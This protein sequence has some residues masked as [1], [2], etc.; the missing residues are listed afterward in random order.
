[1]TIGEFFGTLQ[2]SITAEWRKHLQTNK[3]SEH[4]ILDDFYKE[5]PEKVDSLIEAYQADNGIV[6]D[7]KN[8][9]DEGMGALEYLEA[10]KEVVEEGR[11]LFDSTEL[12]SL[13][14]DILS[15]IDSTIYK[16]KHLKESMVSL[17]D[18]LIESLS[19]GTLNE[20]LLMPTSILR[21][22]I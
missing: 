22:P 3:Y 8:L 12:E 14:D 10:L 16:L 13:T 19:R 6:E 18:Y 2:E 20:E 15:L 7:Y 11:E 9:L 21:N 17:S 4:E 5:M 1:M